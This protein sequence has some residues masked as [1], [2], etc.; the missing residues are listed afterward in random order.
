MPL[1][2]QKP[3][4]NSALLQN[5][6]T[7]QFCYCSC[8]GIEQRA[9]TFVFWERR[10]PFF[11]FSSCLLCPSPRPS[12]GGSEMRLKAAFQGKKAPL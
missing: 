9:P 10:K 11:D 8:L 7:S 12:S 5:I 6:K 2:T 3:P 4:P 1:P